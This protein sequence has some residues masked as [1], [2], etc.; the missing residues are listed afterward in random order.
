MESRIS[1][2]NAKQLIKKAVKAVKLD[3]SISEQVKN[4]RLFLI[5][6]VDSSNCPPA[7]QEMLVEMVNGF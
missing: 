5:S 6:I 7:E 4:H 2:K 3:R 1:R